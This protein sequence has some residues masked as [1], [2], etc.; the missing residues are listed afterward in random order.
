MET[1]LREEEPQLKESL[2]SVYYH[3]SK[4]PECFPTIIQC[5]QIAMTLGVSSASAERSFS[6]LGRLKTHLHSTMTQERLTNLAL[7]YIERDLSSQLWDKLDELVIAFTQ[8]TQNR[9]V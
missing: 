5:Y 6:S 2:H 4:V 9:I 1:F 8:Y 3:L 7:L